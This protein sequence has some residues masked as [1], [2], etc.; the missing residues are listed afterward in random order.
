MLLIGSSSVL[1]WNSTYQ[2]RSVLEL[3][4]T[5]LEQY[6]TLPYRVGF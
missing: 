3:Y 2:F 6:G 5:G 4:H 1:D